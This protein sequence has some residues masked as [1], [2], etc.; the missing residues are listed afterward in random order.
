MGR[1][2]TDDLT[3]AVGAPKAARNASSSGR[4]SPTIGRGDQTTAP[5]SSGLDRPL[6]A[7]GRT[8]RHAPD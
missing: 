5:A 8:D 4:A 2:R 3:I 1:A 6:I 7:L